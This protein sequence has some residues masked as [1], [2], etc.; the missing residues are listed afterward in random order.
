MDNT[1]KETYSFKILQNKK[2]TVVLNKNDFTRKGGWNSAKNKNNLRT[3]WCEDPKTYR[4][5]SDM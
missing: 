2:N 1:I 5:E 4:T 3:Y